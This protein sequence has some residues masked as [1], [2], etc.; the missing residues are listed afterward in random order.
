MDGP[1]LFLEFQNFADIFSEKS[2][3]FFSINISV[4]Y[5]IK[6]IKEIEIPYNSFY[7]LSEKELKILKKFLKKNF[8]KG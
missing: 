1:T 8:I 5:T 2:A 3:V 6:L 4:T 7:L